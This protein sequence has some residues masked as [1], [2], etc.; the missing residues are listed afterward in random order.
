MIFLIKPH[1]LALFCPYNTL[2]YSNTKTMDVSL[3]FFLFMYNITIPGI[4][5]N[6]FSSYKNSSY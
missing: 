1:V 6:P 2:Y 3:S 5:V 4:P